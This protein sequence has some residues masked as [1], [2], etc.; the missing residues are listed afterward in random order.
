ME[1]PR[2]PRSGRSSEHAPPAFQFYP[3]DW[4]TGRV[5]EM[6]LEERGA[7]ITLLCHAW[8]A[9]S[10]PADT[11]ALARILGVGVEAIQRLLPSI[12]RCW[13]PAADQRLIQVRLERERELLVA[14]RNRRSATS[15][16]GGL[17]RVEKAVRSPNGRL[18]PARPG[19]A[20]GDADQPDVQPENQQQ[21]ASAS[22]STVKATPPARGARGGSRGRAA[23]WKP[24]HQETDALAEYLGD[25]IAA[26]K[27]DARIET[28]SVT[29][30]REIDRLLLADGRDPKRVKA[31]SWWLFRGGPD[32]YDPGPGST[33]DWRPNVASG[34]SLRK[35]Y[36]KL[37]TLMKKTH[38]G[39][40]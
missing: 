24:K 32:G 36:D 28:A 22:T 16:A 1:S 3:A 39:R 7:Y 27:P 14:Y 19:D 10:I 17:A 23:P 34:G 21:P 13:Q 33:F 15:S 20:A 6:S 12:R 37:D 40:P 38:G 9:G 26:W 29:S 25:C 11:E 31:L 2:L 35:A 8:T 30:R 4:A 18:L 5:A